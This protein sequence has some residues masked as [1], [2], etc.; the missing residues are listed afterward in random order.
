[1]QR[2]GARRRD[3]VVTAELQILQNSEIRKPEDLAKMNPCG[4]WTPRP[5]ERIMKLP[6]IT[7]SVIAWSFLA[8]AVIVFS[9]LFP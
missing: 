5:S 2:P 4:A 3:G 9:E 8:T 7:A 1:V 6:F